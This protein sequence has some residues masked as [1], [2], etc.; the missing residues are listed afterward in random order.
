MKTRCFAL[1]LLF[2]VAGCTSSSGKDF[3]DTKLAKIHY[4]QTSRQQ[5]I[6]LFGQPT[7]E[8]PYPEGH[9]LMMWSY[10]QAKAMSTTEGKTLTVQLDD[11]KVKS[12]TVSKT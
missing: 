6:D 11:G 12:Y 5:L 4:G 3:D 9:L 1:L 2:A 8:T 7:T 10:S